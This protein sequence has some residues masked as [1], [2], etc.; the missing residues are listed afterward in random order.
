MLKSLTS[1]VLKHCDHAH[2]QPRGFHLSWNEHLYCFARRHPQ[3]NLRGPAAC[4]HRRIFECVYLSALGYLQPSTPGRILGWTPNE[5]SADVCL[6][7]I[8]AESQPALKVSF[9][10][11]RPRSQQARAGRAC[12]LVVYFFSRQLGQ[13]VINVFFKD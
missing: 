1:L 7:S 10:R 13:V 4:G 8:L 12:V 2:R 9:N 5:H 6:D 3:L 11:T